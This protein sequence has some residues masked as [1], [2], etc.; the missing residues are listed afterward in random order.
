MFLKDVHLLEALTKTKI[1]GIDPA[2]VKHMMGNT[3][4]IKYFN[5]AENLDPSLIE[6]MNA[7]LDTVK[8]DAEFEIANHILENE[9]L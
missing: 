7:K 6:Y 3:L 2:R 9:K 4:K 8:Q 5:D 1:S